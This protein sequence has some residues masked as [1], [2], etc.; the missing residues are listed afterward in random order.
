M[1]K[2]ERGAMAALRAAAVL[3]VTF[4]FEALRLL[5]DPLRAIV[6]FLPQ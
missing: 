5:E 2:T 3:T 4:F 1:E 6:N